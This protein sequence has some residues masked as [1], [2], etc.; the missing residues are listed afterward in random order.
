LLDDGFASGLLGKSGDAEKRLLARATQRAVD[1]PA[2][3]TAAETEA[4]DRRRGRPGASLD[5]RRAALT[6]PAKKKPAFWRA[7]I[8]QDRPDQKNVYWTPIV[9]K[10]PTAPA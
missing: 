3:L 1:A 8:L 9:K 10:R 5:A 4:E 6:V 7:L 2:A